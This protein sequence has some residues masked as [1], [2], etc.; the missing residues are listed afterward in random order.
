MQLGVKVSLW[1]IYHWIWGLV[2]VGTTFLREG[3][4]TLIY[5]FLSSG[6]IHSLLGVYLRCPGRE[7]KPIPD[8]LYLRVEKRRPHSLLGLCWCLF[9]GGEDESPS[10]SYY[11]QK[12]G[13]QDAHFIS[14]GTALAGKENTALTYLLLPCYPE[15]P[16]LPGEKSRYSTQYPLPWQDGEHPWCLAGIEWMLSKSFLSCW[17]VPFTVLQLET[18]DSS[19][20]L[21]RGAGVVGGDSLALQNYWNYKKISGCQEF[22]GERTIE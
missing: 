20:L 3:I 21:V 8:P 6:S 7:G 19:W 10:G 4:L 18:A 11:C 12:A 16:A 2:S 1:V 17:V 22:W 9:I 15:P 13:V 5:L 14:T